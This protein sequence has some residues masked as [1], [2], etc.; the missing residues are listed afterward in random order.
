MI[1]VRGTY[2]TYIP[3]QRDGKAETYFIAL[4]DIRYV[5]SSGY[6]VCAEYDTD[7]QTAEK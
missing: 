3:D 6:Q 5:I 7:P 4:D 1:H 2:Q